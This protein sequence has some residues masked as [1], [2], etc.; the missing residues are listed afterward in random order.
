[1][2]HIKR[3]SW[4]AFKGIVIFMGLVIIGLF[5]YA[6]CYYNSVEEITITVTDKERIVETADGNTTSKYLVFSD[7]ETFEN[8]DEIIMWKFN[9][10]DVQGQLKKDSTYTVQVIGFRI[11][12]LSTYRNILTIK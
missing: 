7:G 5:T 9:S 4:P 1:M 12:F 2:R 11:P 10:S 8:Q 3:P 6:V